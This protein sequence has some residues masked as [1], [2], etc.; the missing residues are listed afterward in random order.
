MPPLMVGDGS[1]Q[2][3]LGRFES[4]AGYGGGQARSAN[5]SCDGR[6]E[7][8]VRRTPGEAASIRR[9]MGSNPAGLAEC[10]WTSRG[11]R[12]TP[13]PRADSPSQSTTV[14]PVPLSS[15]LRSHGPRKSSTARPVPE[16][17]GF[18][19]FPGGRDLHPAC[20]GRAVDL[21]SPS[22]HSLSP[23]A[24]TPMTSSASSPTRLASS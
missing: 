10:S 22:S 11:Q 8:I 17:V 3:Q 4:H 13:R 5:E 24:V 9:V 1:P 23:H 12:S 6:P 7:V 21:R 2:L 14:I 19:C 15:R 18:P 20:W 16:G